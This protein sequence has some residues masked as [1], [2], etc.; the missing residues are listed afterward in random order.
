MRALPTAVWLLASLHAERQAHARGLVG[1]T[2]V[3]TV[4]ESAR[5]S[6][7]RHAGALHDV[8]VISIAPTAWGGV[9]LLLDGHFLTPPVAMTPGGRRG[10]APHASFFVAHPSHAVAHLSA[11]ENNCSWADYAALHVF[12]EVVVI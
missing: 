2:H 6:T 12:C 7:G 1:Q 11:P 9:S 5:C 3:P 8:R 10:R 4:V